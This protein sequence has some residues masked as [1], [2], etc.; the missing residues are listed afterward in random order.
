MLRLHMYGSASS[1]SYHLSVHTHG[2][3]ATV[4]VTT[5]GLAELV[6][7]HCSALLAQPRNCRLSRVRKVFG[8][9]WALVGLASPGPHRRNTTLDPK[10]MRPPPVDPGILS[11]A[12]PILTP[13]CL[14]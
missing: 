11:P 4:A 8:E 2:A 6:S 1:H 3:S 7:M 9:R 10:T 12:T 14:C 13:K 5:R